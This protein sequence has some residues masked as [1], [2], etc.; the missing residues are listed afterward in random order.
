MW[1]FT[2]N[3]ISYFSWTVSPT[4]L[5]VVLMFVFA[6]LVVFLFS[7]PIAGILTLAERKIAGHVQSRYGPNMVLGHGFFQWA[8]DG[9][10]LVLKEDIIPR[11]ADQ[12]LFR[13]APYLV[14]MGFCGTL[15]CIPFSDRWIVSDLNIGILYILSISSITVAGIIMSGWA[16]NNKWSAL[17]GLRAAAQIISYEIP[18]GLGVLVVVL[19]SQSLSLQKIVEAQGGGWGILNWNIWPWVNPFATIAFFIYFIAGIAEI[20]RTP[21]D[22]PEAESELVSGYNTEYSGI[23]FG[24]FFVAEFGNIFVLSAFATALFL[25]GWH[26]PVSA[27]WLQTIDWS[28]I[29]LFGNFMEHF[30]IPY[31]FAGACIFMVKT[32]VLMAFILFLRWT[33]PRVRVDQ[34]MSMNW[35]YLVPLGIFSVLGTA[36]WMLI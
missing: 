3:L 26:I 21:F 33:L 2:E 28:F 15:V 24:M 1:Q 18:I 29:P 4:V 22:I 32:T 6:T 16:S 7:L 23:R 8:A 12:L 5:Y 30:D 19:M 14:V 34:L 9:I 11:Q 17:G 25:G 31:R 27:S 10:K 20:N 13:Y 35:Q 36:V